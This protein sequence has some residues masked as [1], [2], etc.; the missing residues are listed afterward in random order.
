MIMAIFPAAKS[1]SQLHAALHRELDKLLT[2]F[3]PRQ[4]LLLAMDGP[5][6]LAKLLTQ[7]W[8]IPESF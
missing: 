2:R 6:P 7:R 8:E 1:P 3:K 4:T 5:A